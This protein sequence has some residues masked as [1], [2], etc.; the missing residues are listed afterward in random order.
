M[1]KLKDTTNR[2]LAAW[3][4]KDLESYFQ[5]YDRDAR[6]HGLAPMMVGLDGATEVYQAFFSAFPDIHTHV[7]DMIE[8]GE[9]LAVRYHVH[10]THHGEFQ[11]IPATEREIMIGGMSIL[12][13]V[14]GKV[15]ERWNQL[16]RMAM[17]QQLGVFPT[18]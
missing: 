11:G 1:S 2:A 4:E 18:Q 10:G 12:R 5:L 17:L 9:T 13:F 8:D 7:E 6:I 15:V 16:D 3:N 14:S